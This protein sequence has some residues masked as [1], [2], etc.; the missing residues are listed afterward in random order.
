MHETPMLCH[1]KSDLYEPAYSSSNAMDYLSFAKHALLETIVRQLHHDIEEDKVEDHVGASLKLAKL[2]YGI[3][4][5]NQRKGL[6][7]KQELQHE[8]LGSHQLSHEPHSNSGL[9]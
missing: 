4:C 8:T 5:D 1:Y 7:R 6:S 3:I 9:G 2:A